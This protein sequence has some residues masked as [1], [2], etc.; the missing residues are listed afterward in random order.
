MNEVMCTAEDLGIRI[1]YQDTD[2]MHIEKDRLNDLANEFKSRFGRELIGKNLGQFHND[3]DEVKDGF[4][5]KSI[6]CG[7]K[8]Y[9]DMLQND[10]NEHGIHYRMKG[11]SLNTVAKV[12]KDSYEN[13]LFELYH[14]L[15]D[16]KKINF[17]LLSTAPRFKNT[18]ARTVTNCDKF[19]RGVSFDKSIKRNEVN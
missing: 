2:S 5:Y 10:N 16:G 19:A 12:A 6:F 13:N 11:V 18:K 17:N 7:K 14:E 3:F 8:V 9:I 1:F 15:Y 4:A